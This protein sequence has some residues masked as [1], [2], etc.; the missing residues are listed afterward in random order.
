MMVGSNSKH[1]NI[2]GTN[3]KTQKIVAF[4]S[5]IICDSIDGRVGKI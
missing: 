1:I 3:K 5:I 4:G 2:V